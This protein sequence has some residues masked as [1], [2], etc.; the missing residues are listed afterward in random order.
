MKPSLPDEAIQMIHQALLQKQTQRTGV[1]K[2]ARE[3]LRKTATKGD[4]AKNNFYRAGR[5][6]LLQARRRA[7]FSRGGDKVGGLWLLLL[8]AFTRYV[9]HLLAVVALGLLVPLRAVT[10]QVVTLS[11]PATRHTT[12]IVLCI[13]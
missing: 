2:E 11:A 4:K 9:A 12:A 10:G 3:R 7:R 8:G 6:P 1:E 13:G 5:G